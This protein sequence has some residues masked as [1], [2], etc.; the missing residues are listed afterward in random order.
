LGPGTHTI[1]VV[2]NDSANPPNSGIYSITVTV[3]TV[4]PAVVIDSLAAGTTLSGITTVSGW[5]IDSTTSIGTAIANVQIKVDGTVVGLASY[6]VNR[7]DVCSVYPGRPGCPNV[8]FTYQLNS[9]SLGTG[10]HTVT[11]VA[12]DSDNPPDSGSYSVMVK[13]AAAPPTTT[14]LVSSLSPSTYAQNVTL[15]ATVSPAPGSGTVTFEASGMVLGTKTLAN[16][17]AALTVNTLPTGTTS[18]KA[19]YSGGSSFAPSTSAALPQTVI[20]VSANG[21]QTPVTYAAGTNPHGVVVSDF[22]GDGK[23]DIALANTGSNS[24]SVL[25][26]NGNGTFNGAQNYTAGTAPASVAIGDFNGDGKVDLAVSNAGGNNVS[27]L[28]GNGD[29]TFQPA[30][31]YAAGAG[32]SAVTAGDFNGDGKVDLAISNAGGNNVSVLLGNGDGTF[33]PAA[34]YAVGAAPSAVAIGDFNGDGK[35]DLAVSNAGG[36]SMSVLSGNGDGTFQS[37]VNYAVGAGPSAVAIG[38]FNGDGKVDLA[39]SNAGGNSV[40]VLLGNGDGTFRSAVT[41]AAGNAPSAIVA[42]DFNGDNRTDLAVTNASTNSVNVLTGNGDGTFTA[43]V[44]ATASLQPVSLAVGDFNGD[45]RADLAVAIAGSNSVS[46]LAGAPNIP[47][48]PAIMIDSIPPGAAVSGVVTISGWA[49]GGVSATAIG[50]IQVL[51]DALNV[52]KGIYGTSRGDVC[53]VYTGRQ[54][55]PNVGFTYQLNTS[56]LPAGL[57]TILV[58]ATDLNGNPFVATYSTTIMTTPLPNGVCLQ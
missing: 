15:G 38:D 11:A 31:N 57:H 17:Q 47:N 16:G 21:F 46:V 49:V 55:C 7:S 5:A 1:T 51:V 40:S 39:V 42:G 28:L 27:V 52:G 54:G 19:Y 24:V 22:N 29:G 37:A 4:L 6:G 41:Y 58:A 26:G 32:P 23:A 36:N 20:G 14:T 33:Q 48:G 56:A 2:A 43:P 3:T 9:A 35:V 13:V 8:G 25:L 53:V 44:S 10:T 12:N 30:A 18:L 45:G 50:G 34:N